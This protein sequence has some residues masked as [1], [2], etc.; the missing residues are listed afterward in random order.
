MSEYETHRGK[1]IPVD[2][3]GQSLED[4]CKDILDDSGY[5][6]DYTEW[7]QAFDEI[8]SEDYIIYKDTLY[9]IEDIEKRVED[10]F[11]EATK[12]KETSVINYDMTFY[13]GGT[14]L[15]EMLEEV[16]KIV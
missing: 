16:F 4:Y 3:E 1:L 15:R 14:C 11:L 6:Y 12:D 7:K 8:M 5:V 13:N 9:L 2:L 10:S